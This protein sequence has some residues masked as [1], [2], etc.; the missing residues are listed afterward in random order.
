MGE[1]EYEMVEPGAAE[2]ETGKYAVVEAGC[3]KYEDGAAENGEL[4]DE[5]DK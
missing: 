2:E 3:E 1:D 5:G 4:E